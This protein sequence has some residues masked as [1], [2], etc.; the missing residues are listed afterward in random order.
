[1]VQVVDR[2]LTTEV[3]STLCCMWKNK[4]RKEVEDE[5]GEKGREG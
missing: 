1:M 5:M 2:L 3:V 4:K